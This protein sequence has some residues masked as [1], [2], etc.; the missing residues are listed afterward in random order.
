MTPARILVVEDD[1]VVARDI[2]YQLTRI[3]HTVVDIVLGNV[4]DHPGNSPTPEPVRTVARSA[5]AASI[6]PWSFQDR[7]RICS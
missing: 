6:G 5:H 7:A 2:Q 1:R 4:D 3:G